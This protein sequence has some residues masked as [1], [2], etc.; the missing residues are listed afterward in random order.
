MPRIVAFPASDPQFAACMDIRMEVFVG[1]QNVPPEEERDEHD[2]DALHFLAWHA[3]LAVGTARVI[4]KAANTAKIT[5]VAVRQAGR[6][7]GVGAALMLAIEAAPQLADVDAFVLDAQ[8]HALE[9]YR[10][11][12]YTTQGGSFMEA[13]IPH[14]RMRKSRSL[15]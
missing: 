11:L 3:D 4:R 9:F 7:Q 14:Q 15:L 1:E 8:L 13:G 5:R 10:R 12:G 6:G 2:A